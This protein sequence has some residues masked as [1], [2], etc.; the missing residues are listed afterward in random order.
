MKLTSTLDQMDRKY[1]IYI[2]ISE[3]EMCEARMTMDDFERHMLRELEKDPSIS[4]TLMILERVTSQLEI[5]K[6]QTTLTETKVGEE[7]IAIPNKIE[8]PK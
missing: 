1:R 5:L 8:E 2:E 3:S 7:V 4:A 6:N